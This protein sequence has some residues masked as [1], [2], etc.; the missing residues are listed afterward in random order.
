MNDEF[1]ME[2]VVDYHNV[3]KR[4]IDYVDKPTEDEPFYTVNV[5]GIYTEKGHALNGKEVFLMVTLSKTDV[6]GEEIPVDDESE[7]EFMET[8]CWLTNLPK[9]PKKEP[10]MSDR[11]DFTSTFWFPKTEN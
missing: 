7:T 2:T 6:R 10:G 11:S 9:D 8:E 1:P 3:K 5:R 4:T